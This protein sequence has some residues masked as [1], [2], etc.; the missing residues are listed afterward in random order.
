[1]KKVISVFLFIWGFCAM[2]SGCDMKK[3][4][5]LQVA[6]PDSIE[7]S[8]QL[9]N[10]GGESWTVMV[11]LC[12][13]DLE[14]EGGFAS[15]NIK[16][17]MGA[18][19]SE[20]VNILIQTG[21]T[22]S[23]EIEEI[24]TEELQR[25]Q[26]ISGNIKLIGTSPLASM[27]E[28][29]TL[30]DFL[31]WGVENFPAAKYACILWNH[32]S[33]S[34]EGVAFD[35]VFGMDSLDLKELSQGVSE[36]GVQFELIGFDACLMATLETAAA[37][38]P[39]GRYMVASQE[40]EPG[41]GW[42]YIAMLNSLAENS[43]Q[44]GLELGKVICDS[45]YEKCAAE[46]M[47][48]LVTLS[49]TE[50]SKVPALVQ[51]FDQMAAEMKGFTALPEKL[52]P[53]TQAILR[54]E[55]Y[56]GNNDNEGYSNMVDL[57][58]IAMNA[59]DVVSQTG[60]ALLESLESAV[61]YA[62]EGSSRNRSNGLSIYVPLLMDDSQLDRYAAVAVS[63]EYLRFLEGIYDWT[64][65][66]DVVI[67]QPVLPVS[68]EDETVPMEVQEVPVSGLNV[69]QALNQSDFS[70]NISTALSED[71]YVI[72]NIDEGAE[73]VQSVAYSLFYL[74]EE[75]NS[76]LFLGSDYDLNSNDEGS[77]YWDNFRNVWPVINGN[78]CS[79]LPLE[80]GE[81]YI[82]Y[83][84]PIL[85]N[86]EPTNLRMTYYYE[87]SSYKV[88]G[89]WDGIDSETGVSSREVRR[90]QTGDKVEFSFGAAYLDT[91]E[92]YRFEYGGFTVDG[93]IVVEEAELFDAQFYYQ[94]EVTDIFGNVHTS[95]FA[96]INSENGDI[97][98]EMEN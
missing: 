92:G 30:G 40:M 1:M 86:G 37:L 56:G 54:A 35:E 48:S 38:A 98:V 72:L 77:V 51:D 17:M 10:S 4:K 69:A 33:G 25:Y 41:S 60:S 34:V 9:S 94:Y 89:T 85:L 79:M 84:V 70:V 27:G 43:A 87:D 75:S 62:V 67:N 81:D 68:Q 61:P 57:G 96:V 58:D 59:E 20:D 18:V 29:D 78:T 97:T 23:W 88:I 22:R 14:S 44:T 55:N 93:D 15:S 91:E 16:E 7:S 90:L 2:L 31:S 32:G 95:D 65:P 49:V 39:Y 82:L 71:G 76:L 26:I 47:E 19:A 46:G 42:D 24:N 13:T 28:A 73:I 50:L 80:W 36:A 66:E 8:V 21:G 5:S 63:G 83:T 64:I 74:D 6:A 11:Y 53:L 12:G 3:M 52:Q 45:F